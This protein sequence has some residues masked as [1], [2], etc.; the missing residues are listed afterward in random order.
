MTKKNCGRSRNCNI[1]MKLNVKKIKNNSIKK[2]QTYNNL[3]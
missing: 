2:N 3:Q 1:I